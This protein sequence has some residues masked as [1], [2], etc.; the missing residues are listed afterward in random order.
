MNMN[1]NYIEKNPIQ[2]INSASQEDIEKL[3]YQ[4][5]DNYYNTEDG[6]ILISD[7]VFD[8][9]KDYLD[10]TFPDSKFLSQIGSTIKNGKVKLPIHM[11]S[12]NK[13][14]TE[15]DIDK[16][17]KTYPDEV[18]LS[19]KLDGISFLLNKKNGKIQILTRGNGKEGKD[20]SK[21]QDFVNI[22]K[23]N[24][25]NKKKD[26]MVRGE[27]LVSKENY[28]K[29]KDEFAN[30]RSFVAGMSNQKDFSKKEEYLKLVDFVVYELIEPIMKPSEQMEFLKDLGF[31]VVRNEIRTNINFN[32]LSS[33]MLERKKH[34]NY[35]IDGLIITNNNINIRNIDGNP[36][37]SFAFKMD[38]DFAI[39]KVINVEWN[40]SKHGKLK[41]VVYIEPTLLCGTTNRKATGNN[42][43]FIVKNGIGPGAVIKMIKGG[44]IIPK[45]VEVLEKTEPQLPEVEYKW[46]KTHKEIILLNMEEDTSVK[47]KRIITFFKTLK[48][49][50][51][52]PGLYN[53][54]YDGGF[55]T[56]KEIMN[57]RVEDLLELDGIKEKSAN[58]IY[59][60]IHNVI[61]KDLEIEKIITGSSILDSVGYK[62]LKKITSK[63]PKIFYEDM[64]IT[65]EM[66]NEI[67][68]I[69]EKTSIKIMEKLPKIKEFLL[70]HNQLKFKKKKI[71]I[72]KN[73]VKEKPKLLNNKNIVITGKRDKKIL[74]KIELDGGVIQNTVN[75]KTD[76]LIVETIESQSSKMKKAKELN[77][78]ILTNEMF[79]M[80][81]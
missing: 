66:L 2:F 31:Q 45:I 74:E 12:M 49:E 67:P 58:K 29:V 32:D 77:I 4:C 46:N 63:Y 3:L 36:K 11:G 54:M 23:L 70:E 44:E 51:I 78:E 26:F 33:I 35:E 80:K 64:D 43:D 61:D 18:L 34:S 52:G 10:L 40:A 60:S 14:K 71:V 62:I 28:I 65:I 1:F 72:K 6:N 22:N 79:M 8:T 68:S 17:I 53:K 15:K 73:E 5:S 21:I 56:I 39:T 30:P 41:P 50:N 57:I 47:F 13:K 25:L 24:K 7:Q 27:I 55:H 69:Q 19:D 38:L 37:Y 9:I 81:Y 42:A 75:K 16:W 76:I 48:V 20:I 59:D